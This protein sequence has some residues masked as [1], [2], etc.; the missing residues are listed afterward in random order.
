MAFRGAIAPLEL[1]PFEDSA[2]ATLLLSSIGN[3]G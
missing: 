2:E 1:Y 3:S